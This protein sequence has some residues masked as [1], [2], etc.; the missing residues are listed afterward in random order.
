MIGLGPLLDRQLHYVCGKGGV[1]KSVVA[2][3][4]ARH[5]HGRGLRV[6]LLQVNAPDSHS[7]LLGT[8][9]I[10]HELREERIAGPGTL[11]V[12]NATSAAA[13]KEYA[14]MTLKFESLYSAVFENR[15]TKVFL[16]F[17]PS[18]MELT[19][20]GKIWFHSEEKDERGRPRFD[21]I[22][23]DCPSTGHGLRFLRV[24]HI[25]RD[26]ARVGPMAEKTRLMASV[27]EDP[28]RTAL[29][30]VSL[31][32]ELPVNEARDLV[33]ELRRSQSAPLGALFLNQRLQR[34]FDEDAERALAHVRATPIRDDALAQLL[35]VADRRRQRE[36]VEREQRARLEALGMPVVEFPMLLVA[37][38]GR[39]E[40]DGLAALLGAGA[41]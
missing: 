9:P 38:L 26:A 5:F 34:L 24:A 37:P 10:D 7:G 31:P 17:V 12:V 39:T 15:L 13:M 22:V 21:R 1:G 3:A 16:R 8:A 20:Q 33:G 14:L 36:V 2:C 18:L 11:H 27:I 6:L 28:A 29:H 30:V 35:E 25:I 41:P 23:V 32:E 19:I 4:L 40:I